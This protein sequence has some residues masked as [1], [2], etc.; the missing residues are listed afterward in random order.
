MKKKL[1]DIPRVALCGRRNAGKSTMLNALYGKNRAITDETP[2][3]TRDVLEVEIRH[4]GHRFLLSDLPGLDIDDPSDLEGLAL[5]KAKKHLE[6]MDL[7]ILLLES[8]HMHPY[9]HLLVDLLRKIKVPVCYAVNKI[10]G[11][12]KADMLL[13]EFYEAGL[14]SAVPVSAASGWN[15]KTLLGRMAELV[16]EIV[17]PSAV[18]TSDISTVIS[19]SQSEDLRIAIAGRPNEGKSSLFNR[20]IQKELSLVSEVPGTTRD[21]IDSLFNYNGRTIRV[22]DTAGLRRNSYVYEEKNK[23]E[24]FSIARTKRGIQDSKVVIHL[25]DALEGITDF[26]KKI[27]SLILE[28]RKPCVIGVNKWDAVENK[29]NK[30]V[31]EYLDRIYFLFPYARKY[32]V[33]FLSALTGQ[34]LDKLIDACIDINERMAVRVP[35]AK[36]NKLLEQWNGT[37]KT[38]EASSRIMY[39]VQVESAPPEF[40]FFIKSKK[41]F[42]GNF[43]AFFE[44]KLRKEYALEGI[45]IT[46]HIR[47]RE[48]KS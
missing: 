18:K 7:I 9:D 35:T 38:G 3:L 23:I 40:V 12:E 11:P 10:D 2:G 31:E 36:L 14:T 45:P 24:R 13:A 26:D 29:D 44:N 42:R 33:I 47:E 25:V 19:D 4:K 32:P 16:P 6:E 28:L 48:E 22:I 34:R 15:I 20:L 1:K 41:N 5:Q 8:P 46:I 43:Q 39:A 37:L 30:S 17:N 21:T 27:S